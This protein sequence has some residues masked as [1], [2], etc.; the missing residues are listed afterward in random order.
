MVL[1]IVSVAH[2]WGGG[3]GGGGGGAQAG[4][5]VPNVHGCESNK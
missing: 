2:L 3:G 1:T 4:C 5:D